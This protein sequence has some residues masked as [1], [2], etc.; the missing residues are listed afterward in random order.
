ML[1]KRAGA[2]PQFGHL[3]AA[4]GAEF[5]FESADAFFGS[6]TTTLIRIE[7]PSEYR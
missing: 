4:H 3:G 7:E 2:R 1:R 6:W 5:R